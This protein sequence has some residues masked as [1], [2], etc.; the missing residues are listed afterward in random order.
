LQS[1]I[2]GCNSVST[3]DCDW[4]HISHCLFQVNL[5]HI[6]CPGFPKGMEQS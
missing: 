5:L 4:Y 6:S 1:T 2:D 3:L